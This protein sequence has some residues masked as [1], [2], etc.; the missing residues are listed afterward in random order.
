M[1]YV[2]F[3]GSQ[4]AK[5]GFSGYFCDKIKYAFLSGANNSYFPTV[6]VMSLFTNNV[7]LSSAFLPVSGKQIDNF[8]LLGENNFSVNICCLTATGFYDLI[9]GNEAGYTKLSDMDYLIE[10]V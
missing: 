8:I 9:V 10:Y 6:S 3:T 1:N 4:T 5:L 7:R 2:T